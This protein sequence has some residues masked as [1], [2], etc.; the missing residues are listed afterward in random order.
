MFH[1]QQTQ[2]NFIDGLDVRLLYYGLHISIYS[3][4]NNVLT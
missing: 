1:I 4:Y 3:V 2:F